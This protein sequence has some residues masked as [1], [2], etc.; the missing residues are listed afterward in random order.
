M[1]DLYLHDDVAAE[2]NN[3]SKYQKEPY[4]LT[5]HMAREDN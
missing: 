2:E 3:Q 1:S 4:T 5:P